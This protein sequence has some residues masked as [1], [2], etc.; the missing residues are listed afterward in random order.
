MFRKIAH[1]SLSFLL[2]ISTVG[3]TISRH[4]CGS[5]LVEVSINSEADPCCDDMGT[6][7]C[8]HN[9]TEYF[10]LDVDFLSP[11]STENIQVTDWYVLFP[12]V[13]DCFIDAPNIEI[14]ISNFAE[15]PPIPTIQ[16]RLSLLQTYLC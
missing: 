1:I 3:F 7:T 13:S 14:E 6:S 8:C 12:L 16:T 10:Q 9:E 5:K 4:Y 2:L 15:S 11:V